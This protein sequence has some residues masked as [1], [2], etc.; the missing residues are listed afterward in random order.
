MNV[1]DVAL[2]VIL[3]ISVAGGLWKGL[4]R[5]V[6]AL[7]GVLA[8]ILIAIL[9]SPQLAPA[10]ERWIHN[11]SA[12]YAAALVILFL[13][14]LIAAAV[15]AWLITKVVELAQLGPL[16]RLLGGAFGVVRALVIGLFLVLGLTL[17][18]EP[19]SPVLARSTLLPYLSWGARLMAPLLPE[20]PR[21]VLLDRLD[22]LP[23]ARRPS[24]SV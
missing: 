9:F 13:G 15:L 3:G 8:G 11:A 12:A 5:E 17:F 19:S 2:L 22:R 1:L 4:V 10:L 23:A 24:T 6:F 7:V 18:L 16:N 20:E 21:A 14:T